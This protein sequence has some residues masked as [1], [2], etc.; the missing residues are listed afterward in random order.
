MATHLC[1][2]RESSD[3]KSF[4]VSPSSILQTKELT[5]QFG[6]VPV[7]HAVN[8]ELRA[9]EVHAL[10]GANGAG[11]STFCRILAGLIGK[12]SGQLQIAG[13]SFEPRSKRDAEHAGVEIVQQELNLISTLTVAENLL[14][15]RLPQRFGIVRRKILNAEAAKM[16]RRVG[17]G[18]LSPSTTTGT[19]G[20]G[21][22]QMIEIAGALGRDCRVLI[23]DEP[24]A[25]LSHREVELLFEQIRQLTSLGKGIIYVSHRLDEIKSLADRVT[26]LRDGRHVTTQPAIELSTEQMI[27]AMSGP[28]AANRATPKS[29][30]R[31]VNGEVRS[32]DTVQGDALRVEGISSGIVR[33]VSF[34]VRKGEIVGITGLVGAGRTELLRAIFGADRAEAGRVFIGDDPVG[35]QF[36]TPQEAVSRGLAFVTEDRKESGLLLPTS[37]EQNSTLATLWRSFSR[38]GW[39]RFAAERQAATRMIHRLDIRCNSSTQSVGQLSGGNQQ[40]VVVAKWLERD[41]SVFLFDE[42][43]RGV[44]V[45]ARRRIYEVMRDLANEG[46]GIVMVSSD[47]EELFEASDR[48][49]VMS[50]GRMIEGF[51][52]ADWNRDVLMEAAFAGHRNESFA[53]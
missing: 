7:L 13:S 39:I 21:Q 5:K 52:R 46:K 27:Q 33:D 32:N 40:K 8:F 2:L 51:S 19:L 35:Y 47:L 3:K 23:L 41:A 43:T 28:A 34:A 42:P 16:L 31:L 24:T 49:L 48:I 6:D 4:L 1:L 36:K 26:I 50:A 44:D 18:D 15:S 10:I 14:L 30:N 12:T 45:A 37:I 38:L 9:G 22:Q 29:R 53:S 25:A 11:K 17:L 20:V